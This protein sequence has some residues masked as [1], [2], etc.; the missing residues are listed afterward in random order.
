MAVL[1]LVGLIMRKRA[2]AQQPLAARIGSMQYAGAGPDRAEAAAKSYDVSM[3]GA[4]I[5]SNLGTASSIPADFDAEG[6]ER[7]AKVQFIRLQA[8]NDAGNLEDIREF[9]TP[10]MFAEL[11]LDMTAR[12]GVAQETDVVSVEAKVIEVVEEGDRYVVSVRFAG[13]IRDGKGALPESFEET[14]HLV[15]SRE[16]KGGWVLSGIQQM[17]AS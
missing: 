3:P 1:A 4:S 11:K 5:G 17:Q 15:K 12:A 10:E 8:A 9:T 7:N 13:M 14:W 16:G 2:A 6:F